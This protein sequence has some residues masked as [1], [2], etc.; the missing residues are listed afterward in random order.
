MNKLSSLLLAA[1]PCFVACA[2]Q[3]YRVDVGPFFARATGDVALQSASG[4][5]FDKNDFDGDLGLDDTEPSPYVRLQM[6]KERHRVRI[7]GFGVDSDGSGTLLNAYGGIP[8]GSTVTTAMEFFSIAGNWG[9]QIARGENYRIAIGAQ[10]GYYSLDVAARSTAG[11]EEVQT[12]VL[13]P[14]PFAE[15]EGLFGAFTVGVNGAVIAAD[16]GDGSGRYLDVEAYARW[17][18]AKDFDFFG[19]Y[20]YVV[21]DAYGRATS[22]DFDADVDVQGFFFGA[23][24]RF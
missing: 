10:A 18:A 9:Y 24:I 3:T 13:A 7:H 5:S 11:R 21:L 4:G 20:R 8:A 1:L 12:D 14:M 17:S 22:R 2:G 6:D 23:G 19:G 15:V 16:L